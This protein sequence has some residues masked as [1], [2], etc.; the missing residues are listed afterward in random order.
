MKKLA[1]A[2]VL[3]AFAL[4]GCGDKKLTLAEIRN[5]TPGMLGQTI[6]TQGYFSSSSEQDLLTGENGRFVDIVDLAVFPA[7][8][9]DQRKAKREELGNRLG[10]KLV[11]VR[12]QLKVGPYGM[13]GRSTV[14]IAVESISE[15]TSAAE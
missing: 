4:S 1:L 13:T 2:F 7:I 8:P 14:F 3:L 11:T 12:G 15:A 10:G 9:K 5:P 6:V